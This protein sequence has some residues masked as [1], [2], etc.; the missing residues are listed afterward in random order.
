MQDFNSK[1]KNNAPK[2]LGVSVEEDPLY[3]EKLQSIFDQVAAAL[4]TNQANEEN[5]QEL[6]V[7]V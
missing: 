1:N 5:K 3:K 4:I 7:V 2:Y 6:D